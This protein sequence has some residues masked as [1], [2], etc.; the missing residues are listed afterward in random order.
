LIDLSVLDSFSLVVL[1]LLLVVIPALGVMEFDL[2][3]RWVRAG[4]QDARVRCF[5]WITIFEYALT[6]ALLVWWFVRGG[7]AAAIGLVPRVFQWQWLGVAGSLLLSFLVILQMNMV[8]GSDEQLQKVR[9]SLGRLRFMAP[10]DDREQAHF[11]HVSIAAG[12]CEEIL[13]RGFLMQLLTGVVGH[14]PAL[15]LVAVVFGMGH[16]YQ[17][18]E[19]LLKTGGV[20]LALGLL[21][22]ASG[23]LYVVMI[24]HA[25]L[26]LTS[27]R[28]MQAAVNLPA[29]RPQTLEPAD[30]QEPES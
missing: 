18:K 22:W 15:V 7:D 9:D 10:R 23:S 26:D 19:G 17:G 14:W 20:G 11:L 25:V 4:R 2:L 12:I 29:P 5:R 16:L 21:A 8:L 3:S 6:G 13:Y 27:G 30:G 1:A 28:I 24:L